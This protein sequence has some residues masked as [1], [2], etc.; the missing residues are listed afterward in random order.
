VKKL[1]TALCLVAVLVFMLNCRPAEEG[2]SEM[3]AE[4]PKPMMDLA[5]VRQEIDA[6]NAKF[7]EAVRA[8]DAA[9]LASLYAEDAILLPPQNMP[10][11]KGRAAAE[12]SFTIAIQMGW[13]DIVLT[14]IDVVRMGDMVC[15]IG[16]AESTTQPEGMDVIKDSG[17]YLV[18]WKKD[19]A[20]AW[21]IYIDIWQ[22][23]QPPM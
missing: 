1:S 5:Q 2:T 21:K 6:A 11:V 18:I 22:S 19:A 8:G 9:A 17:K 23:N 4:Q 7:G 16:T 14:T 15:E 10:M 20:G 12:E 13:N 3:R